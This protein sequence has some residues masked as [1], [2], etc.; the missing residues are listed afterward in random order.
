MRPDTLTRSNARYSARGLAVILHEVDFREFISYCRALPDLGYAAYLASFQRRM[1]LIRETGLRVLVG[2]FLID[3]HISYADRIGAPPFSALALRAFGS[4]VTQTSPHTREWRGEPVDRFIA[5]LRA[6][7][8]P[9]NLSRAP[10]CCDERPPR[11]WAAD[12]L[13]TAG[14]IHCQFPF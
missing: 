9:T 11:T 14:R 2:P 1:A 13:A 4:F 5:S 12:L 8:G 7:E 10:P 6:A 3:Q